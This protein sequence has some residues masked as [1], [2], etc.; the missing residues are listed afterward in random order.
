M[1]FGS[2]LDLLQSIEDSNNQ[3]RQ[4]ND[5]KN[6]NKVGFEFKH[7]LAMVQIDLE[8]SDLM[9]NSSIKI[10]D[11]KAGGTLDMINGNLNLA[12]SLSSA[13][14]IN[15]RGYFRTYLPAQELLNTNSFKIQH[16]GKNYEYKIPSPPTLEMGKYY[17]YLI[18]PKK[19][20]EKI[21]SWPNTYVVK[22]GDVLFI[23]VG[24]PYE[25]WS[26]TTNN[27]TNTQTLTGNQKAELLWM[28]EKSLIK[29]AQNILVKGHID[30][31][32]YNAI[33]IQT[34][35][36]EGNA[37]VALKVDG[38]IVWSWQIWVTDDSP[39]DVY[40]APSD[41][42]F[43]DRNLGATSAEVADARAVGLYYQWGRKDPFPGTESWNT[44]D[45]AW[46]KMYDASN[47]IIDT[48]FT[49]LKSVSGPQNVDYTLNNPDV[50][51]KIQ[52]VNYFDWV[53]DAPKFNLW[54]DN[55]KKSVYDP[56]PQ[57]WKV[58]AWKNEKSPWVDFSDAGNVWGGYKSPFKPSNKGA[59]LS[60][61]YFPYAG[62]RNG[63]PYYKGALSDL[64]TAGNYW[65][66]ATIEA[67]ANNVEIVKAGRTLYFTAG[68][69]NPSAYSYKVNGLPVRCVKEK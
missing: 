24:K 6:D 1:P 10:E 39:K 7:L 54:D 8:N 15:E 5:G 53:V 16:N 18:T 44:V 48:D 64:T 46:T 28:D 27:I 69:V 43:L 4:A 3:D 59:E 35:D 26:S 23:P 41:E 42:F 31:E 60:S 66:S 51:I 36:K 30:G 62:Y 29:N 2:D 14:M 40:Y 32:K 13:Q 57:G 50:F 68:G 34:N 33:K 45:T 58:P 65:T 25:V 47:K 56:C 22:K 52:D 63:N 11:V 9:S 67:T 19:A 17:E 20:D 38:S 21:E 49:N 55:G 12:T 37:V 61:V